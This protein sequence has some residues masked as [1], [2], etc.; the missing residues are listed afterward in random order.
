VISRREVLQAVLAS[1]AGAVVSLAQTG[2]APKA[3]PLA[4]DAVTQDWPSFLGPSHNAVSAETKLTRKL[5]PVLVWEFRKGTG[6]TTPV[7]AGQH[8]VFAHRLNDEEIVECLRPE[9]GASEWQFRYPT[10]FEDRYGYNNGPDRVPSS[11][12]SAFT[13]SARS[14]RCIA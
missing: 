6:Y 5:P 1:A 9:T 7:I 10:D 12:G 3:K 14:A 4:R 2:A 11:M 8:L 13:L